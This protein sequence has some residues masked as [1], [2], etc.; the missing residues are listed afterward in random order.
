MTEVGR[1]TKQ[2]ANAK[3]SKQWWVYFQEEQN[4][5]CSWCRMKWGMQ[6]TRCNRL[7]LGRLDRASK[8]SGR[9]GLYPLKGIN[10]GV[11]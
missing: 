11:V 7:L 2:T 4:D 8:T 5:Q 10:R 6:K 1:K 3:T 9:L